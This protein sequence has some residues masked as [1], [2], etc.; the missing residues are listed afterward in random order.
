MKTGLPF[1]RL[2]G[3]LAAGAERGAPRG[4]NGSAVTPKRLT[5]GST[6]A[7]HSDFVARHPAR[8]PPDVRIDCRQMSGFC[9]QS[10]ARNSTQRREKAA[11]SR[12]QATPKRRTLRSTV[13][14]WR[15]ET[16]ARAAKKRQEVGVVAAFWRQGA[17][18]D[19]ARKRLAIKMI[20]L[21]DVW[22]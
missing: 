20:L 19:A 12:A 5:S 2:R 13:A 10:A 9:R 7:R 16:A 4:E 11:G 6:A 18:F 15:H 17:R 3:A 1:N 22:R 8:L 21:L 14:S